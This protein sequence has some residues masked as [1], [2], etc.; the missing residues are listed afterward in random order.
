MHSA[1]IVGFPGGVSGEELTC[2]C[3]RGK[4]TASI[5]G[6]PGGRHAT[7]LQYSYLENPMD[8]GAWQATLHQVTESPEL[9]K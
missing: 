5:R 3:R 4:N 9:E 7:P 6:S 8:R 1:Q 2:Q